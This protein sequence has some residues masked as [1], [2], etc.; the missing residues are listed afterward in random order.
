MSL[1]PQTLQDKKR[2]GRHRIQEAMASGHLIETSSHLHA[3]LW[4]DP[5]AE[6]EA[7]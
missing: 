5:A 6:D 4:K 1:R 7:S 2:D 3:Q